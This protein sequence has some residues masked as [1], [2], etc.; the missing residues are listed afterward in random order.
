M[1]LKTGDLFLPECEKVA[2][3]P[4]GVENRRSPPVLISGTGYTDIPH[5]GNM[6]GEHSA[7][8]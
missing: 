4:G 2:Y 8:H 5:R 7:Q 6:R 3:K 1:L